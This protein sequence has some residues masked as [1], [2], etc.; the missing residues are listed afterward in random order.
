MI[1]KYSGGA[2]AGDNAGMSNAQWFATGVAAKTLAAQPGIAGAV[3]VSPQ[4]AAAAADQAAFVAA[5]AESDRARVI[6]M[7]G[8]A[9]KLLQQLGDADAKARLADLDKLESSVPPV[10]DFVLTTCRA[11]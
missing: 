6:L 4:V 1:A 8:Q 2:T 7:F 10:L 5:F 11:R 9:V 3:T